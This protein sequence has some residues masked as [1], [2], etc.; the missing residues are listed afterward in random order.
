[1]P[2]TAVETCLWRC[3]TNK[4]YHPPNVVAAAANAE[5]EAKDGGLFCGN[6]GRL[7]RQLELQHNNNDSTEAKF[8]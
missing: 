4:E 5:C 8:Y 7:E 6:G 3:L 2:K 1:M